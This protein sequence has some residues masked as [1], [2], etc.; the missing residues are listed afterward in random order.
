MFLEVS[1]SPGK[2][3]KDQRQDGGPDDSPNNRERLSFDVDCKHFRESK[4]ACQPYTDVC[5]N[6]PNDDRDQ[7]SSKGIAGEGLA[8]STDNPSDQQQYKQSSECH[9]Y[10][11]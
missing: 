1:A 7:A 9:F 10:L 3:A 2:Q 11:R 6:K 4:L 8:D 5:A